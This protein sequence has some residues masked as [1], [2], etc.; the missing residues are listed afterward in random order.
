MDPRLDALVGLCAELCSPACAGRAPGSPEGRAA[1]AVVVRALA[2]A[3]ADPA[4]PGG[5][6]EQQVPGSGGANVVARVRGRGGGRSVLL[7][8]HYDHLGR[9]GERDAF[10]GADDNAAAVAILVE[11]ARVLALAPAAGDVWICAFDSEEPPYFLTPAMGSERFAREPPLPLGELALMVA[12]DLVGHALG[13][14]ELPTAVRDTLFVFGAEQASGLG[15]LVDALSAPAGLWP[16][17]AG[18]EVLPP[19]SDHQPF[20]DRGVPNL[21]VTGGRWRHYHQPTDTPDRLDYP[22]MAATVRWLEQLLRAVAAAGPPLRF[23]PAARDP[24][25]TVRTMAAL[26]EQATP[27][28]PPALAERVARLAPQARA[29]GERG[30]AP[31]GFLELRMLLA[32]IEGRLA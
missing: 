23:R 16:R 8:A 22:R 4:A 1:R 21:F 10:F 30:L 27:P 25:S 28:W 18:L 20:R 13:G 12:L 7:G 24:E 9:L 2:Q 19:L 14:P 31:A 26:C 15:A 11:T 6:W 32:E 29:A 17:R 5:G 3:G